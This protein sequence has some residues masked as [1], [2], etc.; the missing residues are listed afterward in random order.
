MNKRRRFGFSAVEVGDIVMSQVRQ[1][2][3]SLLGWDRLPRA[4][5]ERVL[6]LT[7]KIHNAPLKFIPGTDPIRIAKASLAAEGS[8]ELLCQG[9][10]SQSLQL[11][12]RFL[13]LGQ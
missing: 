2:V 9:L 11:H 1:H 8:K 13:A 12:T 4:G 6:V 7:S 5:M 3:L 10:D